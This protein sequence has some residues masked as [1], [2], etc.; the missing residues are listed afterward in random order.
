MIALEI[1]LA[2]LCD[3]WGGDMA[4][5]AIKQLS[6]SDLT[7]FRWHYENRN[8]GNQKAINLNADVFVDILYPDVR[9]V[10]DSQG[11]HVPVVLTMFGPAG[12][13]AYRVTRKVITGAAYKNW[14]LNGEFVGNPDGEPGRFDILQPNDLVVMSFHGVSA[15][16]A[17]DMIF[18]AASDEPALHAALSHHIPGGRVTMATISLE[19]L[20]DAVAAAATPSAHPVRLLLADPAFEEALEEAVT[21]SA[22]GVQLVESRRGRRR[23]T[24]ADLRKAKQKAEQVGAD[25]EGAVNAYL[26]EC[27]ASGLIADFIWSSQADAT[28]PLDFRVTELSG[29][30]LKIDVK[31]TEGPFG[32]PIHLSAAEVVEAAQSGEPYHV[33]RIYEMGP[34]GAKLRVSSDVRQQAKSILDA[35]SALPRGVTPDAFTVDV[36]ALVWAAAITV[37]VTDG[38]S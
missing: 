12:L 5:I 33:Y 3:Y 4:K 34:S 27:K 22:K 6:A 38:D 15:P 7:F 29:Q 13:G 11:G 35:L 24:L 31:S 8:A 21:G 1:K 28:G 18:I 2:Y 30:V 26:A 17:I 19:A 36:D 14:R 16:H 10:A 20:D 9:T 25:G 23:I 37:A 32:R